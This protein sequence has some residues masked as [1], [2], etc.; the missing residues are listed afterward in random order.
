MSNS[1]QSGKVRPRM[2]RFLYEVATFFLLLI[3]GAYI[4]DAFLTENLKKYP[5]GDSG[6]WNEIFAGR[7]NSEV[8]VYGASRAWV[9]FDPRIMEES[10]GMTVYNLGVD[11]HNFWLEYLRHSMLLKY[12]TKP[13]VIVM[14][15]SQN[16]LAK[17]K[18]LYGLDQFLPY[19]LNQPQVEAAISSYEGYRYLDFHIP[20]FRY[21][22]KAE[23]LVRA[24]IQFLNPSH[25]SPNR[26]KGYQGKNSAWSGDWERVKRDL[27]P[28]KAVNDLESI[29]LFDSFLEECRILGIKVVFVSS[30]EFIEAQQYVTNREEIFSIFEA[31]SAKYNIPYLDYSKNFISYKTEYFYNS[32]HLNKGGAELFTKKLVVDLKPL[33][34]N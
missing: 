3:M 9:H 31:M 27:Q 33:L 8:V 29:R 5:V 16:T 6:I 13:K 26:V 10:L 19:M 4:I 2:K 24:L 1:D 11:G 15:I 12:N 23:A 17:R 21:Y 14:E 7:V 28:S 30:P 25:Y 34:A 18:D 32:G 22:G 20:L